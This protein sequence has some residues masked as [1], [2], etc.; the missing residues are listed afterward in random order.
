MNGRG[1][2]PG[3]PEVSLRGGVSGGGSIAKTGEWLGRHVRTV[4]SRCGGWAVQLGARGS[5]G[6]RA[7]A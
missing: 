4:R 1:S 5:G 6:Q 2:C 7:F 3:L